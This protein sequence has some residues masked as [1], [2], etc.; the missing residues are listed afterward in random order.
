MLIE[1]AKIQFIGTQEVK[2]FNNHIVGYAIIKTRRS[3]CK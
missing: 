2:S 3:V 1:I